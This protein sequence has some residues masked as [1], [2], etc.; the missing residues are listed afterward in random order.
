MSSAKRVLISIFGGPI[1]MA[2]IVILPATGRIKL[3]MLRLAAPEAG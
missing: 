3:Q 1:G 2:D